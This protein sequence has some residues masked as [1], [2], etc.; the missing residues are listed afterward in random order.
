MRGI[1]FDMKHGKRVKHKK[2]FFLTGLSN[3]ADVDSSLV[4]PGLRNFYERTK[5]KAPLE[6]TK[7][8]ETVRIPK[9][10]QKCGSNI[11]TRN[12]AWVHM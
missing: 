4:T 5:K 8:T 2:V 1:E 10:Y 12:T 11:R 3:S 6:E 9:R 7:S